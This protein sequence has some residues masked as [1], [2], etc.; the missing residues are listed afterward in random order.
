MDRLGPPL[1][2]ERSVY[3]VGAKAQMT[4][5]LHICY[6]IE[7]GQPP[8]TLCRKGPH[9]IAASCVLRTFADQPVVAAGQ[10]SD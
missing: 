7:E 2:F 1:F 4:G 8:H 6:P 5:R 3:E 10:F 9:K